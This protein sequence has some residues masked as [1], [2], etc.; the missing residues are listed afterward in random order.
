MRNRTGTRRR[1]KTRKKEES[2][3][4]KD[5]KKSTKVIIFFLMI[6]FFAVIFAV[7]NLGSQK[8]LSGITINGLSVSGLTMEEAKAYINQT[9]LEKIH[10]GIKMTH[11]GQEYIFELNELNI[12]Y[13]FDQQLLDAYKIGRSGNIVQD[14][15]TILYMLFN[16]KEFNFNI[17]YKQDLFQRQLDYLE[18]QL[19]DRSVENKYYIEGNELIIVK[20]LDGV[21]LN[22]DAIKKV[23]QTQLSD[24][25]IKKLID[26]PVINKPVDDLKIEEIHNEIYQE[27]QNAYY[28]VEPFKIYPHVVGIDFAI[29]NEEIAEKLAKVDT[30]Y[31]IPLKLTEPEI[32]TENLDINVF[33]DLLS[34]FDTVYD[35]NDKNK[36]N[37]L[38]IAMEKINGVILK[39][40]ETFSYNKTLGARTIEN[41]YKEAPIY[42]NGK[43]VNGLGG[44]I[45]QGSTTL[46]NAVVMAD[47]KVEERQN[48]MFVP[49]YVKAGHDATVVYGSID[50]RF[51]N[52]REYPIKI[53]ASANSGVARVSIYGIYREKE[54]IIQLETET[55]EVTPYET[56]YISD[57]KLASG[58]HQIIQAGMKGTKVETYKVVK[59]G[60]YEVSRELISVDTY[61]PMQETILK[62]R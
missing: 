19:P 62:G 40:G 14:N 51:T 50:F 41:G 28:T 17:T 32:T 23:V 53:V 11:D 43:I 49:S 16:K 12:E 21:V 31:V 26:L 30:D 48:H 8:F 54:Y 33:P 3:T 42:A 9:M 1:R 4:I 58:E 37:N 20:G 27:A 24:L 34:Q 47:L 25:T 61:R 36:T 38:T 59:I 15:F 29:G 55:L 13:N 2:V 39:P 6:A 52:T 46:Y 18:I 10:N 45:C 56:I 57:S 5:N 44:G 35:T 7:L 22:E 60:N